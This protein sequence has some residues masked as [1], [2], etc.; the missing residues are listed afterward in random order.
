LASAIQNVWQTRRI[1][2][3]NKELL[4]LVNEKEILLKQK[5]FLLGEVNHRVQNS[6]TLVSSFLSM[7]ARESTDEATREAIEEARRRIFAVSL[8]HRRLYG[9]DQVR[10]VDGSRYL[11]EL[12]DDLLAS[13][14]NGWSEHLKRDLHPV[15]LPNDRAIS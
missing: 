7:Q 8:V 11:D 9:S 2:D 12:L 14:D 5:E 6:L 10:T 1:S 15:L 13:I 4:N 3:L